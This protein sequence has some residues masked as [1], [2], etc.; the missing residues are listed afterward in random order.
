VKAEQKKKVA[1]SCKLRSSLHHQMPSTGNAHNSEGGSST[2][3]SR[4]SLSYLV[5]TA[6]HAQEQNDRYPHDIT[7]IVQ[8]VFEGADEF[9]DEPAVGFTV[10]RDGD[11]GGEWG[12]DL[13][14]EC[15]LRRV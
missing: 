12:R 9:G 7:S 4:G 13:Y 2:S 6:G 11:G 3:R 15:A 14:C 5:S 8:L 1:A 10:K